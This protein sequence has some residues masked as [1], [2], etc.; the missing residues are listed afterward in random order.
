MS[1][2]FWLTVAV[3]SAVLLGWVLFVSVAECSACIGQYCAFDMDCPSGCNCAKAPWD[4]T[5]QCW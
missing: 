1:K 4:T 3:C 5:G 2:P